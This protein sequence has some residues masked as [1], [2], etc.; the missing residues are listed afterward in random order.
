MQNLAYVTVRYLMLLIIPK[1]ERN[2]VVRKIHHFVYLSELL[3]ASLMVP[4]S[5]LLKTYLDA[6]HLENL[7]Y[8]LKESSWGPLLGLKDGN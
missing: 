5:K 3:L 7:Y 1:L 4:I 6:D 2:L 8:L